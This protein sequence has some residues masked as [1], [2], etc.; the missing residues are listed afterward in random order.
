MEFQIEGRI[1]YLILGEL[2]V[3]V[4]SLSS[5]KNRILYKATK[6]F[7]WPSFGVRNIPD[8]R[9]HLRAPRSS[10]HLKNEHVSMVIDG[11]FLSAC[12]TLKASCMV[13]LGF[14]DLGPSS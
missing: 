14:L 3:I 7:S 11:P 12:D 6:P 13:R 8:V 4:H 10:M 9:V 1:Q 5:F 2:Q